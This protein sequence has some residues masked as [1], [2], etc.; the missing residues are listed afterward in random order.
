MTE[1]V[2]GLEYSVDSLGRRLGDR[3][4]DG[5][6]RFSVMR[7]QID[8]IEARLAPKPADKWKAAGLIL[9]GAV[10]LFTWVWQ[11]ARYPDRS[12][13]AALSAKVDGFRSDVNE[14]LDHVRDAEQR[15]ATAAVLLRREVEAL[16]AELARLRVE[17][18]T[19]ARAG[20]R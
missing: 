1:R 16:Q 19:R 5:A 18:A 10:L 3:L 6:E 11:A 7:R 4:D 14:R 15:N 20:R 13:Y 2:I 9:T 8:Q 12:E 17:L